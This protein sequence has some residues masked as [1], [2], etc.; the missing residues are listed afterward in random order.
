M[1]S[2]YLVDDEP[3]MIDALIKIIEKLPD[4]YRVSGYS[5]TPAAALE[6]ILANA[7]DVL[8]TDIKMPGING[9]DLISKFCSTSPDTAVIVVSGF[10]D[11]AYVREAFIL[12][13][14][15]YILKPV[16]PQK[17]ISLLENLAVKLGNRH[18]PDKNETAPIAAQGQGRD[19][20]LIGQLQAYL[21]S[22][23]NEDNSIQ[24]VCRV[25]A[26]SQP[27]LSKLCKKHL[28]CTYNEYL[29][30]VKIDRAKQL[31]SGT[32]DLLIGTIAERTGYA[33]QFYFSHVFK[34]ATGMTP[35]EFRT[36]RLISGK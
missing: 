3:F 5:F 8:I 29:T 19:D 32:E 24:D 30:Q 36:A 7:P 17:F 6:Q 22:H 12:G 13:V 9:L 15:D 21:A 16:V 1:Y 23:L 35:S 31:L 11:F 28:N 25:L 4:V 20:R 33:N 26:I 14:E 18:V 2:V 10:D 34:L 27:V